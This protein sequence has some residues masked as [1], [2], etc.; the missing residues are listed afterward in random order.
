VEPYQ[1]AASSVVTIFCQISPM[2]PSRGSGTGDTCHQPSGA[3]DDIWNVAVTPLP[4]LAVAVIVMVMV[5]EEGRATTSTSPVES[6][7]ALALLLLHVTVWFAAEVG[8]TVTESWRV[9]N[10]PTELP[11]CHTPETI[12]P[13]VGV[14]G[15]MVK[16]V[17][18][19]GLTVIVEVE[20]KFPSDVVAVIVA[21]PLATPV[22][23]PDALTVA[24]LDAEVDQFTA[25]FEALEG[26][27]V[28]VSCWVPPTKIVAVVGDTDTP[29]TETVAAFTVMVEAEVKPP[30][31][32]FA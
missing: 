19:T 8:D 1:N 18:R 5:P 10:C 32:V 17:T 3:E 22:T 27:T 6:T 21:V 13:A 20:V 16:L 25:G 11:F 14:P 28:A 24:M 2:P 26:A 4:S 15:M 31:V 29:V 30:S 12:E 7:V 23:N 9:S